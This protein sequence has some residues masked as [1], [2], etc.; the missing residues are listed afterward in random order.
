[1]ADTPN[2]KIPY[3]PQGTLDPAAGLNLS[4][5]VIDVLL[6]ASVK[7]MT[8]NTPPGSPDDGDRYV[9]AAG[10][11]GAWDGLD[12]HLV[13]YVSEGDFWQSYVPGE[14]VVMVLNQENGFLY[15]YNA[16]VIPAEW[17][18]LG[19]GGFAPVDSITDA[20]TSALPT[21]AGIYN[22][23]NHSTAQFEFDDAEAFIVGQEFH[24]RY[25]GSGL[26]TLVEAG[27]MTINP[28]TGG[29]LEIPPGGTFTVK[30]V[31]SDEAD[32]FGITVP[33]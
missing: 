22:R 1:M 3:V 25:V 27:G 26:L 20:T 2:A 33:A 4:L 28:P 14:Q 23:F 18:L 24:G 19:V 15:L 7:S 8:L 5:N 17:Y 10:G 21:M 11:T 32:L 31:A 12:D 16:S 29:T 13:R 6:Q 30:I 9:V